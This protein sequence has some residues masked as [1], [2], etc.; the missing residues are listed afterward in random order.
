[1]LGASAGFDDSTVATHVYTIENAAFENFSGGS[2]IRA[3]GVTVTIDNCLFKGFR[4]TSATSYSHV[5]VRLN[6]AEAT[7]INSVFVDNKTPMVICHNYDGDGSQTNLTVSGCLFDENE[8]T[9]NGVVYYVE[10]GDCAVTG[11][12]FVDNKVDNNGN[13]AT[14]YLGFQSGCTVT[15]NLFENNAVNTTHASSKRVAGA[16]FVGNNNVVTGNAFIGN[17]STRNGEDSGLGQVVAS[18]YYNPIDLSDNYWGGEAPVPGEDYFVE[19]PTANELV[20]DSYYN[21][22]VVD[23]NGGVITVNS[24]TGVAL[25]KTTLALT[26]GAKETLTATVTPDNATNPAVV[27]TSSNEAVATVDANGVVTAVGLG[28]ATITVTTVDGDFTASCAVTVAAPATGDMQLVLWT[29]LMAMAAAAF[30]V[31]RKYAT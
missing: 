1:M 15:G 6:F 28:N 2:V 30:V 23:D 29:S 27:W 8:V 21:D 9:G 19:Y 12:Q 4:A 14:L 31:L 24:V 22:Y 17:T 11:N 5:L 18:V 20:L 7:V 3:Q 25:N 26:N 10:G 16:L 13:C